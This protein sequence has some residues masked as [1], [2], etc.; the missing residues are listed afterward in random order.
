M[1]SPFP[2]PFRPGAGHSPP[3][4]AGRSAEQTQFRRHLDQNPILENIVLTGLRGVGKTVLLETFKPIAQA[5]HWLWVGNELS[6]SGSVTEE[7]LATRLLT[8]IATVTSSF[9]ISGDVRTGIGFVP[10]TSHEVIPT[11]YE[12]WLKVYNTQPG[13]VADKIKYVLEYLWNVLPK[14]RIPG[15]V[16]AYDEAQ[17]ISDHS[18]KNEYPLSVLLDVFQSIQ[19]KNICF[20]LTLTGLPT[21]FPKLVEA[22]TYS[23][24]MFH[25]LFLSQ[26]SPDDS[27]DAV[28]KPTQVKGCPIAFSNQTVERIVSVSG[29]YPYF[30]QFICREVFDVWIQRIDS[31]EETAIPE[32]EIV[33]KLDND[34][35]AGRWARATDR[36]RQLLQVIAS[37]PNCDD[38]FTVQDVSQSSKNILKKGFSPSHVNQML[39]SLSQAGLVYK[40]RHGRYSFSVPLLSQFINRQNILDELNW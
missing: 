34:F 25:V 21:L 13:L 28:V 8:D 18:E 27:K 24:R 10:T 19:R 17:N 26:L 33:R 31:G 22:R 12:F 3:Y 9:S 38:E 4:L 40:N 1:K 15:I 14:E 35:F 2:N 20:I 39:L 36:Q 5:K 7:T 23:E 30:I 29:G 32:S 6:E 11:N 37:L 16:F